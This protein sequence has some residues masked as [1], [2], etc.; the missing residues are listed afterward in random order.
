MTRKMSTIEDT[1][2]S[3][4]LRLGDF[5]KYQIYV[6]S[7]VCV[8]TFMHSMVHIVYVFTAMDL[9]YRCKVPGCDLEK[10]PNYNEPW[11]SDAI[12]FTNDKPEKCSRF[13]LLNSSLL[14]DN[15][16]RKFDKNLRETCEEFIYDGTEQTILQEYHLQCNENL[17]KLTIVGTVNNIGQFFGLILSGFISDRYGRRILLVST[18]V[19][20]SICGCIKSV[21]PTYEM[22]LVMEF[23][24]AFFGAGS[25]ICGFVL[26]VELVGPRKRVLTG[27]IIS[28]CYALGEILVASFAWLLKSWRHLLWVTYIPSLLTLSYLWLIPESVRWN[29]SKGRAEEAKKTLTKLALTNGKTITEKELE[30]I[31]TIIKDQNGDDLDKSGLAE[32]LKSSCLMLRLIACCFCWITCAFLYYGLTLNSVSLVKG[33]NYLDFILTSLIE[34]PAYFTCNLVV[35]KYGR[36]RSLLFSFFLTGAACLA[37]IFIPSSSR[38]SSLSTYLIGKFGATASFTIVYVLTS[39][40]FPTNLRH[41]FMGTCSTIGRFGSMISPQTPLLAQFW[42]PLPLATFAGMSILAGFL[43]L[44]FPETL[45]KKLPDTVKEAENIGKS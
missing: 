33:N 22:F 42:E 27:T 43:T 13:A 25:Y 9:N 30:I 23:L 45:H 1:L 15:C 29:L 36:K 38:W 5:G 2:D 21:M 17:W 4:L 41:S 28:S 39:E 40:M 35:D 34:I 44:T 26:G 16:T 8:A 10:F 20:C 19:L 11:L 18:L 7:L 32:A 3:I 31:E 12:P 24:D 6:F 14:S 37:F